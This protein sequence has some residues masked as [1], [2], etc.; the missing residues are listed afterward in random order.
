MVALLV[1]LFL[2]A[3]LGLIIGLIKPELVIRWGEKRTRGQ[4]LLTYGLATLILFLLIGVTAPPT[5]ELETKTAKTEVKKVTQRE[6]IPFKTLDEKDPSLLKGETRIKQEGVEGE[7]LVTYE[8]EYEN[9]K[10]KSRRKLKEEI[11]KKPVDKIVLVGTLEG[12][13]ATVTR[14]IDGDTIEV[15]INGRREE[16]R[17]I[18]INTPESYQP[19]GAEAT[20][21]NQELVAGKEVRLVKDVSERDKYGRLLRYVYVGDLFVNAELVK[22]GY[23]NASAYPPDVKYSELFKNLEREA[24]EA[25]RGLWA[26]SSEEES[27]SQPTKGQFVGNKRSKKLHNLAHSACQNYVGM[28]NEE[29]KVFFSS[30][31]E[32]IKAGYNLC[33]RCY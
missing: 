8:E 12:E 10:L 27:A 2:L 25:N 20:A 9:G 26:L 5:S 14:V 7:K 16:V 1:V 30:E 23:A 22:Q 21:K 33:K 17:Y 4:V 3:L 19:F 15:E 13:R 6:K 32:G 29:N 24:R 28:M 11:I 31:R 18:G